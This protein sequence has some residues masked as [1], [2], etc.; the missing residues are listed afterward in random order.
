MFRRVVPVVAVLLFLSPLA[1]A[2]ESP[3]EGVLEG[4]TPSGGTVVFPLKHTHAR[5]LV[6]GPV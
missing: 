4:T 1:R 2:A 6:V 5:I 3:G